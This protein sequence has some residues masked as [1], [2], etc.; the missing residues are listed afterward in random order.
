MLNGGG[1]PAHDPAI[2]ALIHP[3]KPYKPLGLDHEKDS[4]VER[5]AGR[6]GCLFSRLQRR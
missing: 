1:I 6:Q 4:Y 2:H 5:V 3:R